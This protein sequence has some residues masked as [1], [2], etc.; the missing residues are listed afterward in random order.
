MAFAVGWIDFDGD[1]NSIG[2]DQRLSTPNMLY[3]TMAMELLQML[4][5]E[6]EAAV[7]ENGLGT[8]RD[9]LAIGD[10]DNVDYPICSLTTFR[11]TPRF[12]VKRCGGNF[13][14]Q[15]R[16]PAPVTRRCLSS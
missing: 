5:D 6:S 15:H 8:S 12:V 7:H 10:Y 1:G 16:A 11:M 2:C 4:V 13:M 9:G 14:M 3:T